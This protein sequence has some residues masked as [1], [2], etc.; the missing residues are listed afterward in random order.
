M[1]NVLGDYPKVWLSNWES[2]ADE[3]K[4][5]VLRSVSWYE[6]KE[7]VPDR[8]KD[9][10]ALRPGVGEPPQILRGEEGSAHNERKI[11][12]L[13]DMKLWD[14]ADWK[15][16][17]FGI[18]QNR[19]LPVLSFLFGNREEGGNV[20][21]H[22]QQKIGQEDIEEKLRI[23]II[24]G[25]DTDNPAAYRIIIGVNLHKAWLREKNSSSNFV[26]ICRIHTME[27]R[28]SRNLD[29]F[30]RLFEEREAYVV[31]SAYVPA[32]FS[33]PEAF[34]A[35]TLKRELSVRS[36]WEIG[37]NDIDLGGL[38]DDDKVIIPDNVTDPPVNLALAQLKRIRQKH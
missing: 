14:R 35:G 19:N 22:L 11:L 31:S 21:T 37:E 23:S 36:A 27:P 1:R 5:S 17:G 13:I 8:K 12:S 25:I 9:A 24:T 34:P 15:G 29:Q 7:K 4:Q 33:T 38:R 6:G 20:S 3:D 30:L 10:N 26:S 18:D 28:D 32:D 16:L 2:G